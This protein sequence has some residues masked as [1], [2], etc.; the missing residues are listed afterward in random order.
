MNISKLEYLKESFLDNSRL[1]YIFSDSPN[2]GEVKFL[3]LIEK[4]L[5]LREKI[6]NSKSIEELTST[7]LE[8]RESVLNSWEKVK[9]SESVSKKLIESYYFESGLNLS[10][11]WVQ[12]KEKMYDNKEN[13]NFFEK[14][15]DAIKNIFGVTQEK[16]KEDL[17]DDTLKRGSELIHKFNLSY[18]DLS[19]C[20]S[21]KK[22]LD[23]LNKFDS[24]A[25]IAFEKMGVLPEVFG[26]HKTISLSNNTTNQAFC[27]SSNKEISL[28]L[29]QTSSSTIIHEWVHALDNY[30]CQTSTSVNGHVSSREDIYF[31][32]DQFPI[33]KAYKEIRNLTQSLF[34]KN[35]EA[36]ENLKKNIV[37]QNTAKFYSIII[38]DD[39]YTLP[40]E[41]RNHLMSEKSISKIN[42]FMSMNQDSQGYAYTEKDLT[43]QIKIAVN[44]F[45]EKVFVG[46]RKEIDIEIKPYFESV[47]KNFIE[48]KSLYYIG[49]QVSNKICAV[50]ILFV[51]SKIDKVK[52]WMNIEDKQVPTNFGINYF[53]DPAEMLARYFESQVFPKFAK[54]A[55]FLAL[56]PIYKVTKDKNFEPYKDKII[57]NVFGKDKILKNIASLRPQNLITTDKFKIN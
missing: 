34:N 46:K 33:T 36:I 22:C 43:D 2:D 16:I 39:W 38:G 51:E 48:N 37:N 25:S 11:K 10:E 44:N 47:N 29:N 19:A 35:P 14:T 12:N 6:S 4:V 21:N 13:S 8:M 15:S 26:M 50:P 18:I 27:S 49:C 17:N 1:N 32:D 7:I 28:D 54:I 3:N 40:E 23:F 45:D 41:K 5:P 42:N 53:S 56:A 57:E 55:N 30:V 52:K 20:S 31:Q 24:N 9:E